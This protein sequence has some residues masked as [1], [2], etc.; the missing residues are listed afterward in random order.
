[1]LTLEI[2]THPYTQELLARARFRSRWFGFAAGVLVGAVVRA[3][4]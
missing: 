1:M 2:E 4:T 3:L